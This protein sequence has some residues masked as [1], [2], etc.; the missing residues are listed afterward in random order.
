MKLSDLNHQSQSFIMLINVEM[1]AIAGILTFMSR[2][3][4]MFSYD[5]NN[6]NNNNIIMSLFSEDDVFSIQY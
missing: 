2:I 5:N 6:N 1:S 4:F 3:N